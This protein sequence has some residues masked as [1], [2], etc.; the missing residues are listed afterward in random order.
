MKPQP[1]RRLFFLPKQRRHSLLVGL[2]LSILLLSS[3]CAFPLELILNAQDGTA[4]EATAVPNPVISI[5]PETTTPGAT[6]AIA[7]AG[8]QAQDVITLKLASS[9]GATAL[10]ESFG[11]A[12]VNENGAFAAA[13]TF[14]SED[15]WLVFTT[16]VVIAE[17]AE[18]GLRVSAPLQVALTAN[19]ATPATT[20]TATVTAISTGT[21]PA[22]FTPTAAASPTSV[23]TVAVPPTATTAAATATTAAPTQPPA[24]TATLVPLGPDQAFITSRAL[25]VRSGPSTAYAIVTAVRYG[26]IVT[27]RGQNSS[28][29]WLLVQLNNGTSGWV[30]SNYTSFQGTAPIVQPSTTP[31]TTATAVPP[32]GVPVT[33]VPITDWR[34]EYFANRSLSGSPNLVRN[35]VSIDF[36]WGS[37]SPAA[38]IPNDNFSVR[39]SRS[40]SFDSGTYRFHV[41]VDDGA[42]LFVD[43][44]LIIDQWQNGSEREFT[45]DRYIN[46]GTSTIRLEYFEETGG[47]R[48]ALWWERIK[49]DDDDDDDDDDYPDWKGEYYDNRDLDD[50]PRFRRNDDE[51]NFNW[52]GGS[53]D[54]RID[55]DNFSVRWTRRVNFNDGRY[56]FSIRADDGVR[57]YIDGNR[58]LDEWHENDYNNGYTLEFDLRG[59]HELKV[60][61]YER[62]GGARVRFDWDRIGDIVTPTPVPPTAT[63]TPV[64][65]TATPVA[66]TNTPVA[67]TATPT[68]TALPTATPTVIQPSAN[69]Q[70]GAGSPGTSVTINGGGFPANTTVNVHLGALVGVRSSA[71]DPTSYASTTT[72]RTGSYSVQFALPA[73]W[74]DGELISTGQLLVMVATDDFGAQATTILNY[75]AGAPTPTN[76]PTN[77]PEPT[78][79]A[80]PGATATNTPV[81]PTATPT[82][83][84]TATPVPQP[85]VNVQ[86]GA[87]TPGT[88]LTVT[89]GGYPASVTVSAYLGIFDGAIGPNDAAVPY[90]STVTDGNGNFTIT[91]VMPETTPGGVLL[92]SGRVAIVV[93]TNGFGLQA[94]TTLDFTGTAPTATPLPTVAAAAKTAVPA[95]ETAD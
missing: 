83:A 65:P 26:T 78:A 32:T 84:V 5:A 55:N 29:S 23:P 37:G 8:W 13:I 3:G 61:Y 81:P 58:V 20:I 66:P 33:S 56:R 82:S 12:T 38:G 30:A 53:P 47:A 86:P 10:E 17:S 92:G 42:R 87:A 45:A 14:P 75:T 64:P 94:A 72:D 6:I 41:R 93:A 35:D 39:W 27:V 46:D 4:G 90:G 1:N 77:T 89:G 70:P 85:F 74:P 51:I 24:P 28:G 67:P 60:E 50:D 11:V 2:L 19:T 49:R 34:G 68:N 43:G 25:N 62:R 88:L 69:V 15:R 7:G 40:I 36:N 59:G 71:T 31:V 73:N 79:T 22:T 9:E 48:A 57:F 63:P 54:S 16:V 91:F 76:T 95:E 52:G 18:S 21:T 44:Q 80:A